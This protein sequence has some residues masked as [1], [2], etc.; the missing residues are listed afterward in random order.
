MWQNY[1]TCPANPQNYQ[2]HVVNLPLELSDL[3]TEPSELSSQ[4]TE[5]L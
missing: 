2:K 5:P 1:E 4:P 3:P